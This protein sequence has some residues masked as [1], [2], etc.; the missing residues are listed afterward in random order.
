V[1]GLALLPA[2]VDLRDDVRHLPARV[3]FGVQVAVCA[4]VLF[5]LGDMPWVSLTPV[6][7]PE[8]EGFQIGG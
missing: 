7:L 2:A 1:L 4:G 6:P 5:A 8:G 3:R